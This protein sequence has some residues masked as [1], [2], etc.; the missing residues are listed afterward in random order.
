MIPIRTTVSSS[1]RGLFADWVPAL[2][3]GVEQNLDE[4]GPDGKL[5]HDDAGRRFLSDYCNWQR[6][7]EYEDFLKHSRCAELG[8]RT[9]GVKDVPGCSTSM[10]W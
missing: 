3:R 7:P 1:S 4:P 6:I 5:Y 10:F 9:D 8:R 2:T